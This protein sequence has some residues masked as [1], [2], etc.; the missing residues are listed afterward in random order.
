MYIDGEGDAATGGREESASVHA[1]T[2]T[3]PTTACPPILLTLPAY[4]SYHHLPSPTHHHPRPSP[5]R[6]RPPPTHHPNV[7]PQSPPHGDSVEPRRRQ[8]GESKCRVHGRTTM[9]MLL[10]PRQTSPRSRP[11][12]THSVCIRP[13]NRRPPQDH[14]P[15]R[16]CTSRSPSALPV[17]SPRLCCSSRRTAR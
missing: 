17:P 11:R 8:R 10:I 14:R 9:H 15:D 5:A 6:P 16:R 3:K 2:N 7:C 12:R 4:P 1:N 13:Q